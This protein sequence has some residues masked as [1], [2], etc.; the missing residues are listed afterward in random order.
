MNCGICISKFTDAG[1][2]IQLPVTTV[3]AEVTCAKGMEEYFAGEKNLWLVDVWK[4]LHMRIKAVKES[5]LE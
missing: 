2:I 5:L 4:H 1:I 3:L